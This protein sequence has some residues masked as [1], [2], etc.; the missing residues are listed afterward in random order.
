VGDPSK[1]AGPSLLLLYLLSDEFEPMAGT[2]GVDA[3]NAVPPALHAEVRENPIVGNSAPSWH[4]WGRALASL[5]RSSSSTWPPCMSRPYASRR[6][7][8]GRPS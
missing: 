7:G 6:S 8:K 4:P 5:L 2:A 3:A 1:P